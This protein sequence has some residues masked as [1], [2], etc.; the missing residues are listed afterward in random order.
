MPSLHFIK[1]SASFD[2]LEGC[3]VRWEWMKEGYVRLEFL[4]ACFVLFVLFSGY[5]SIK[6]HF[7]SS[8]N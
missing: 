7:V 6:H 4:G 8:R 5:I 3:S 2:S 1:K